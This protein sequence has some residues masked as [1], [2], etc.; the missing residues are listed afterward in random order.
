MFFWSEFPLLPDQS[1]STHACGKLLSYQYQLINLGNRFSY[2]IYWETR[3]SFCVLLYE[4]LPSCILN[5][6]TLVTSELTLHYFHLCLF[7]NNNEYDF[8]RYFPI[9]WDLYPNPCFH[10]FG[11]F[12]LDFVTYSFLLLCLCISTFNY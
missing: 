6:M 12:I 1:S 7:F 4:N 11:V 8:L 5:P 2:L 3:V 10:S 9:G